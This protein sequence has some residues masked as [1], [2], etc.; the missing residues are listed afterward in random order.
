MARVSI[1]SAAGQKLLRRKSG[2]IVGSPSGGY[3][4][5]RTREK[6][7]D[8]A[9]ALEKKGEQEVSIADC[10]IMIAIEKGASR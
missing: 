6:A 8:I 9:I 3:S 4:W 1:G 7:D 10:A 2:F 5:H